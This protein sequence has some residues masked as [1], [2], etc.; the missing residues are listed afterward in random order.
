MANRAFTRDDATE[1]GILGACWEMAQASRS[2][3]C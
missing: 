3:C 1:G 2:V